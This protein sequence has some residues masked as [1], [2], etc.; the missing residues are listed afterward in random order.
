MQAINIGIL[1]IG[2]MGM[3]HAT[4]ICQF[5]D[6]HLK[7]VSSSSSDL[8]SEVKVKLNNVDS[9]V[10]HDEII[11]SKD[12]EWLII[13]NNTA[14][15][16]MWALNAL[17]CSKN[18]I[19]EKPIALSLKEAEEIFNLAERKNLK[20]TVHQNRRW[21]K[22]FLLLKKII[23][24]GSLGEIYRIE[25]RYTDYSNTWGAWGAQGEKN[26]WRLDEKSGGG[27]L[28]DWATHLVD[29][30][31][32]LLNSKLSNLSSKTYGVFTSGKVDDHFWSELEFENG[33]DVR[34]EASHNM[35]Y[36]LPRWTVLGDKASFTVPGGLPETWN[37]AFLKKEELG[38]VV[39]LKYDISQNELSTGFYEDFLE[40]LKY[41]K[42]FF[43]KPDEVLQ[44]MSIIEKIRT[45][46]FK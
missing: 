24:E 21:D 35:R 25:S 34:I 19:I 40:A 9:F 13:A 26:P 27:L 10:N 15:H 45:K 46:S 36:P 29:Q 44:T 38:E 22:D 43:V 7:A 31:V 3:E 5:E 42:D 1:G 20:V 32:I 28:N 39:E 37:T 11:K 30:I 14:N 6:F 4:Q 16:K 18:L 41:H 8:L 12:I 33:V 17:N 23:K 2:R